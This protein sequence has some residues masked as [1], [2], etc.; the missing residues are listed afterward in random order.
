MVGVSIQGLSGKTLYIEDSMGDTIVSK[1]KFG[2]VSVHNSMGDVKLAGNFET[3]NVESSMG[4]IEVD[5]EFE[6]TGNL[7]TSMG[8]ITIDGKVEGDTY[9]RMK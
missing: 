9:S 5:D 1:S 2:T 7:H 6:W 4:S 3:L 8:E